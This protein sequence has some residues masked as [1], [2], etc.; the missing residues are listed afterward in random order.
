MDDDL[1]TWQF[2]DNWTTVGIIEEEIK[3]LKSVSP[4]GAAGGAANGD[5][6][7]SA[8]SNI[9]KLAPTSSLLKRNDETMS[10]RNPLSNAAARDHTKDNNYL[11]SNRHVVRVGPPIEVIDEESK[12]SSS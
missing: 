4:G 12:R 1:S 9:G 6:P 2:S 10:L 7:S 3:A 5:R 11:S 8:T